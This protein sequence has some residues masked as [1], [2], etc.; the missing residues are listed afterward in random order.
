MLSISDTVIESVLPYFAERGIDVVFLVPTNTGIAKSIMDATT[1]VRQFLAR[2]GIHNYE[3]QAQ[4]QDSKI[5]LPTFFVNADSLTETNVSLYRPVTKDGDPRI[6]FG[7]LKQYCVARNLLGIVT[8]GEALYV[9]NLS[10]ADVID[11]VCNGGTAAKILDKIS[12]N[13]NAI[14]MELL[15]KLKSIHR[16]GF[17]ETVVRGDTGIGMT[18][19]NLLQIPPNSAKTPDYKGIEIK[20]SRH[21][22]SNKNRVNLFTQ[23]PNWQKSR[24]KT[25]QKLLEIGRAHV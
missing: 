11:S 6:W 1:P 2:N 7:R 8:N 15:S 22:D 18:L 9:F 23:V 4:G 19:E 24:I 3:K 5:I 21:K 16:Q 13:A 12:T 20:S 14:A 17:V 10:N 25:A